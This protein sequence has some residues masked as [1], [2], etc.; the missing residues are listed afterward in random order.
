MLC[1]LEDDGFKAK[2]VLYLYGVV[3]SIRGTDFVNGDVAG[4]GVDSEGV[5]AVDVQLV[6]RSSDR[7][8]G[9][10]S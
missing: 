9:R 8:T 2:V 10:P 6:T 4:G 1:N 7:C 3:A 5:P